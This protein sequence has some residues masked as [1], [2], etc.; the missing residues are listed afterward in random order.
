M[1]KV[2]IQAD[3]DDDI[4]S[5]RFIKVAEVALQECCGCAFEHVHC[6]HVQEQHGNCRES[7]AIYIRDTKAAMV[8]Y[9][10][11]R[12]EPKEQDDELDEVDD[13]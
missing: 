2:W 13:E 10:E 7:N 12:L 8:K 3:E 5:G 9:V 11:L 1:D 4:R 6:G